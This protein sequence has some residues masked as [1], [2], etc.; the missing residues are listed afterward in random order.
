[1][2]PD[3][4]VRQE[5]VSCLHR[6]EEIEEGRDAHEAQRQE[7]GR[8]ADGSVGLMRLVP[9]DIDVPGPDPGID[10]CCAT[11]LCGKS[12][13]L[14]SAFIRRDRRMNEC[15]AGTRDRGFEPKEPD[16]RPPDLRNRRSPT[17]GPPVREPSSRLRAG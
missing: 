11:G 12:S 7:L 4:D 10:A 5:Q 13:L 6:A 3:G 1:M 16:D 15:T 8:A 9:I 17:Q 14:L 2:A